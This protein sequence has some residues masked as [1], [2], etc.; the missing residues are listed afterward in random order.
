MHTVYHPCL[1]VM[2][3]VWKLNVVNDADM[4]FAPV[5]FVL[6]AMCHIV[7]FIALINKFMNEGEMRKFFH[8]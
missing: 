3:S 6:F 4:I 5:G 8:E 1:V 7:R 2:S